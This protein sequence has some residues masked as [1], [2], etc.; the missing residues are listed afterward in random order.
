MVAT[1][2]HEGR[3]T[4]SGRSLKTIVDFAVGSH[5]R[6][7]AL[8]LLVALLSFL[9]GFFSIPPIDRDEAR[10]AQATKQMVE[11]GDYIDIRF[12]DEV[13]YKKPVGIY[14][15]QSGVVKSSPRARLRAS[16]HDDL[17]LPGAVAARRH[18]RCPSDLLGGAC[19]RLAPRRA[20][21]R[22]HDG[23]LRAPWHRTAHRQDRCHAAPHG[24]RCDGGN[25]AGVSPG[26]RERL[27]RGRGLAVG[28]GILE[29]ARRRRA[30]Q[31]AAHRHDCRAG[32]QRAD[33]RRSLCPMAAG[34]Q[35][36]ASE[37]SGSRCWSCHGSSRSSGARGD[38]F[39]A[40]SVGQDLLSKVFAGQESHGAPPGTYFVLF[41][42]TFWPGATLAALATPAVWTSRREP[43][44]KFLLAWLVPSWVVLEL[45]PTKLPHYVLP[46][47]PAIAILIAGVIDAHMLSRRPLLV[48]GTI[49]WFVVP[50]VAG[51]P[52]SSR[53]PSSGGSSGCCYGP[54]GRS[55]GDGLPGVAALSNR[56]RRTLAAARGHR[57]GSDRHCDLCP[58]GP[59]SANFSRA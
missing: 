59:C 44:V 18:R 25:G 23:K 43:A 24:R 28:G 51:L 13:R 19:L 2:D 53:S 32:R 41:W 31:G 37:S 52:A 38:A 39:F 7:V 34:T 15:L 20:A 46:L 48:W 40:E 33:R 10:F 58:G 45:V 49:W 4:V 36:A 55:G 5:P 14:W 54:D 8:L 17:A 11:S 42:L 47:Y 27:E 22:P 50:M 3:R 9:P 29:R 26:Q 57:R 21:R 16:S 56:R 35:T 1:V 6:A 30:A 12:Q